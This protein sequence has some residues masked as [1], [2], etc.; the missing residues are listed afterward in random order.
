MCAFIDYTFFQLVPYLSNPRE[1]LPLLYK[2]RNDGPCESRK[3]SRSNN[4]RRSNSRKGG[5]RKAEGQ[6]PADGEK[7]DS[8]KDDNHNSSQGFILLRLKPD[9]PRSE[10]RVIHQILSSSR[11]RDFETSTEHSVPLDYDDKQSKRTTAILVQWSF[12]AIKSINRKR[13]RGDG[14]KGEMKPSIDATFCVLRKHQCEHQVAAQQVARA[15]RCRPGDVGLAGIKDMQAITYQFCTLRNVDSSRAQRVSNN[16]MGNRIQLSNFV[17]VRG[18]M[19]DRGKLLGNRF[20]ITLRNLKRI[21]RCVKGDGSSKERTVPVDAPHIDAMVKRIRDL[22]FINFYGEQRVGDAGDTSYVGV[23]SFDVGRAMLKGDFPLAVD[24]I[25]TGRSHQVYSPE[26]EE[27]HAREVWKSSGGDARATL[28]A[29]PKNE[30]AMV[31]ERDIMKGLLRYA[32][33]LE[34]IRCVP[35]NA[36]MFWLHG[37]QVRFDEDESNAYYSCFPYLFYFVGLSTPEFH[38]EQS[39]HRADKT[40]RLASY[41]RG[42][43]YSRN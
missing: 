2:F 15:L 17:D 1:D 34:A 26:P 30:C 41:C 22:G 11:R 25:M 35:H 6:R 24:L 10:R 9:L 32:N 38:L 8:S 19:L 20:E 7:K 4:G 31:R 5:K 43:V 39:S 36:R 3:R 42:F 37:Y 21:Q 28:K 33:H 18:F 40:T 23:R 13:K 16:I 27:K 29:F 12:N 14:G